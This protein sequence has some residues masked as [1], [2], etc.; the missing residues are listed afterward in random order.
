MSALY[1]SWRKKFADLMSE[2]R[3]ITPELAS[4]DLP[5]P[6]D[7]ELM[8]LEKSMR[9]N[10]YNCCL[11]AKHLLSAKPTT[12]TTSTTD[13]MVVK[14]PKI[15]VP[16]F[17]GNIVSWHSFWEQF[18]V[19]IHSRTSL[20]KAE[21]LAYLQSSLKDGSAKSVIHGLSQSG[22]HYI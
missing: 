8:K 18:H 15:D 4:L 3:S 14:L 5:R 2:L 9:E 22:D 6:D 19:A 10:I 20:S 13:A 12:V 11:K 1:G 21:K 7:D 17:N 16:H